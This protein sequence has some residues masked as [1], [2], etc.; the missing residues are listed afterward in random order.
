M[1]GG[2]AP[3]RIRSGSMSEAST[4]C[5]IHSTTP[6]VTLLDVTLAVS[7]VKMWVRRGA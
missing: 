2:V 7:R 3:T 5:R 6:A 1:G 4:W